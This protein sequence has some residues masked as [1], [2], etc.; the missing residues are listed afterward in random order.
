MFNAIE[1][2]LRQWLEHGSNTCLPVDN[3]SPSL[4]TAIQQQNNIG[5][6]NFAIGFL[7]QAW[8]DVLSHHR[9]IE[10]KNSNHEANEL[11]GQT[12]LQA[13]FH[14]DMAVWTIRNEQHVGGTPEEQEKRYKTVLLDEV[15]Y[16]YDQFG[17]LPTALQY[18]TRTTIKKWRKANSNTILSWLQQARPILVKVT[19]ERLIQKLSGHQDIRDHFSAR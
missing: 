7:T 6:Q 15:Q 14:F 8:K 17:Q 11:W 4:R 9:P 18:L 3:S 2:G 12:C 10:K 19:R 5:W 1:T 16:T 13:I